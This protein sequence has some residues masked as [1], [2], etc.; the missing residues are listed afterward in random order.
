MG[1][2]VLLLYKYIS[3]RILFFLV[4]VVTFTSSTSIS[5]ISDFI[6][7]E[8]QDRYNGLTGDG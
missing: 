5:Y 8:R 1:Y 2:I 6:M 7:D 4:V 3:L